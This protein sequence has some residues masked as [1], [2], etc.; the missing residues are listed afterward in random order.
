MT[1]TATAARPSKNN[2][3]RNDMTNCFRRKLLHYDAAPRQGN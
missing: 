3:L 1:G 2:G